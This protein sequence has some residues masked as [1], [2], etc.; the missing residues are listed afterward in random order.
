MTSPHFIFIQPPELHYRELILYSHWKMYNELKSWNRW[1]FKRWSRKTHLIPLMHVEKHWSLYGSDENSVGKKNMQHIWWNIY[2]WFVCLSQ[3]VEPGGLL[4]CGHT[5]QL[6]PNLCVGNILWAI[7][8]FL[9]IKCCFLYN[10][11]KHI[12][13]R[14]ERWESG[15]C[16]QLQLWLEANFHLFPQ[17]LNHYHNVDC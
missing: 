6:R 7:K 3:G 5:M 4:V 17:D 10:V 14:K 2:F 12:D 16:H 1:N 13:K 9:A 15:W 11:N 8:Q